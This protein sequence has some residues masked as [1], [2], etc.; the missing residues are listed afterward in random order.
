MTKD[1]V[2]GRQCLEAGGNLRLRG[3]RGQE[4]LAIEE[5]V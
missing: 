3:R 2:K 1:S 5:E 4:T